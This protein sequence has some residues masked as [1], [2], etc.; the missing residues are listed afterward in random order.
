MVDEAAEKV[1]ALTAL[2]EP[3]ARRIRLRA[4]LRKVDTE[5]R[6]LVLRA[7]KANVP[8]RKIAEVTGLTTNTVMLWGRE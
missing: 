1:E 8:I 5:L 4:D 6:P 7:S 3:G 2:Q